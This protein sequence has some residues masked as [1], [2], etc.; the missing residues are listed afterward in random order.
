MRVFSRDLRGSMSVEAVLI[1]PLLF[2]WYVASFQFFDAL[3]EKNVNMKAA[4]TIADMISRERNAIDSD[5][6]NGLNRVFDYLTNSNQ[7]TWIR[8]SSVYWDGE[9]KVYRKSWSWATKNHTKNTDAMIQANKDRIPVMPVGDTVI[10]VE[11]FSA[12]EPIFNVGLNNMWYD[13]FIVT[14]PRFASQVVFEGS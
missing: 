14:R 7:P 6:I 3:R 13:Q 5:Y 9:D 11:T 12:Y 1:L 4:Y 2:W 8:V 10:L